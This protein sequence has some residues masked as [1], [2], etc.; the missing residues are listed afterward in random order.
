MTAREVVVGSNQV[1]GDQ[2]AAT[3]EIITWLLMLWLASMIIA[4]LL[5]VG[6]LDA[7]W[8]AALPVAQEEGRAS[9][10][11]TLESN[12]ER[13]VDYSRDPFNLSQERQQH[14]STFTSLFKV[15]R[16]KPKRTRWDPEPGKG[17]N[18][19]QQQSCT[20]AGGIDFRQKPKKEISVTRVRGLVEGQPGRKEIQ[21]HRS[22]VGSQQFSH[23]QHGGSSHSFTKTRRTLK[24]VTP[25][26]SQPSWIETA[27][28][29]LKK[30]MFSASTSATKE[31]KR[32]KIQEIMNSC[33]MKFVPNGL[34][35][36]ELL[37][38][39][40]VLGESSLKSADQYVGEAKLMQL[41][42]GIQWSDHGETARHGEEGAQT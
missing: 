32:K 15:N 19:S 27:R 41:E 9:A 21:R 17:R 38:L 39:A 40:A 37:T 26:A 13:Q 29:R 36:D 4:F 5:G 31:S 28:A 35:A 22:S 34:T 8:L 11:R 25:L 1:H 33:D 6:V 3:A 42:L 18:P 2:S 10:I 30:R 24:E 16:V 7:M 12:F 20:D 23:R 14:V